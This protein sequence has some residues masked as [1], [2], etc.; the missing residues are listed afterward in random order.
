VET[1]EPKYSN[2]RP[3]VSAYEL[4]IIAQ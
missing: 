1:G 4:S 2:G 3:I